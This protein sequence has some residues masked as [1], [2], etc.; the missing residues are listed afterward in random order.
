MKRLWS[1]LHINIR[2]SIITVA[3][4]AVFSAVI[5]LFVSLPALAALSLLFAA[6]VTVVW[7]EVRNALS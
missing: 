5:A 7:V 2:T 1:S 3:I 6:F 4:I